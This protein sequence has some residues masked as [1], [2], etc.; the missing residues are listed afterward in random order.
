MQAMV[1]EAPATGIAACM[2]HDRCGLYALG[3][4]LCKN[5]TGKKQL[6]FGTTELQLCLV[7]GVVDASFGYSHVKNESR[8]FMT[9]Y[10]IHV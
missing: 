8:E 4:R 1:E 6:V 10:S 3:R 7:R 5:V 2:G 9:R